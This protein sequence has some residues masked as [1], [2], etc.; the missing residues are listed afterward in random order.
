MCP[1]AGLSPGVGLS[2]NV[3]MSSGNMK[4]D[5]VEEPI[6]AMGK[7]FAPLLTSSNAFVAMLQE[8]RTKEFYEQAFDDS[9]KQKVTQAEFESLYSE[10]LSKAGPVQSYKPQQWKFQEQAGG[11]LSIKIVHH[12]EGSVYYTFTFTNAAANRLI[13]VQFK[14]RSSAPAAGAK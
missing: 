8:K 14:A 7:R 2:P 5:D 10:L 4:D 9:L 13:G 12:R 1:N 6:P 3:Y 11:V